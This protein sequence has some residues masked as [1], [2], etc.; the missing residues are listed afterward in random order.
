MVIVRRL[1][2]EKPLSHDADGIV[3]VTQPREGLSED[4]LQK[5]LSP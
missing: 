4:D 3:R 2:K 5:M 1:R